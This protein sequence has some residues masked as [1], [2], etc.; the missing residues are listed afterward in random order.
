MVT[1]QHRADATA[2]ARPVLALRD[3]NFVEICWKDVIVGDLL[4]ID[5]DEPLC[6]DVILV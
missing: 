1:L 5:E 2:N 3:G 4:K 6:A